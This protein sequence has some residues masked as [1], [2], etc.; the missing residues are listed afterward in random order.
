MNNYPRRRSFA[1]ADYS[2]N[3][4]PIPLTSRCC[5]PTVVNS[6]NISNTKA[7]STTRTT[8]LS[9]GKTANY[10][11]FQGRCSQPT[12]T[13]C[14]TLTLRTK[15]H[16]SSV[17][18]LLNELQHF[19]LNS[20]A[21]GSYITTAVVNPSTI[22]DLRQTLLNSAA[23]E[24]ATSLSASTSAATSTTAINNTSNNTATT[25]LSSSPVPLSTS[26]HRNYL[27]KP[28]HNQKYY[29]AIIPSNKVPPEKRIFHR[30]PK[31]DLYYRFQKQNESLYESSSPAE[32][33]FKL[34]LLY[35]F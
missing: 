4:S 6:S 10:Y 13:D 27:K 5:L 22:S 12:I 25:I 15:F 28:L 34:F 7:A 26:A 20:S 19:S 11:C 18:S 2:R 8:C 17:G 21:D 35:C 33:K 32:G 1:Y 31:S 9:P 23:S 16:H 24:S 29:N 30:S 14:G 3:L